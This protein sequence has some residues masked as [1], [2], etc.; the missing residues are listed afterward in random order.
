MSAMRIS[1]G[2]WALVLVIALVGLLAGLHTARAVVFYDGERIPAGVVIEDDVFISGN[3]L[4]IDGTV[5]GDLFASGQD[6]VVNGTVGGSLFIA[7]A[8]LRV[9]GEVQGSVYGAGS[10]LVLGPGASVGRNAYCAGYSLETAEGSLVQQ[11]LLFSGYQAALAGTVNSDVMGAMA[12]LELAGQ[13]G[14]NVNVNVGAP[15]LRMQT[16]WGWTLPG[17]APEAIEPG[18]RVAETAQIGGQLIY[19]SPEPQPESILSQP[20]G[21]VVFRPSEEAD[22]RDGAPSVLAAIGRWI[23]ARLRDLL[24]LL[25]LGGLAVW[26]L[27]RWLNRAADQAWSDPL[28]SLGLGLLV[29][30]LGYIALFALAAIIFVVALLISFISVGGLAWSVFGIGLAVWSLL[31]IVFQ[32]LVSWGSKVVVAYLVGRWLLGRISRD[33]TPNALVS[34]LLGVAIYVLLHAI[35]I[36]GWLVAAVATLIG[37]GAIWLMI[38]RRLRGTRQGA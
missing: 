21:G 23:L 13:V 28:L 25:I 34:L 27:P 7:G 16:L 17:D 22:E 15:G 29:L 5:T 6:V 30:I 12:A 2:R 37:L 33:T 36:V 10:S 14:E 1:K 19:T 9:N 38:Y 4:V 24:T 11:D 35:P 32:L 31:F 3:D 18:L 20:A 26:L 8:T